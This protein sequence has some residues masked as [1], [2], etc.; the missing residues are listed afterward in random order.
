MTAADP[1]RKPLPYGRQWIDEDDVAAVVAAL[2]SDII[3]HGP[4][5][6]A[7]EQAFA[8]KV[9]AMEAVACS[10]GTAALHLALA[11]LDVAPGDVCIVPAITFLSTATAARFGGAEVVF[12]DVDPQSG[13]MTPKTLEAALAHAAR[14]VKAALPVHLGGR[15]CD[16][17]GI[18][19]VC[20]EHNITVVE[21]ASH[22]VGGVDASGAFVGGCA[23]SAAATFSFH[24]VKTLAA[25]EG[26]MATLNDGARAARMRRLRNHGVTH[27]AALMTEPESL[28]D[29]GTRKPW[30]Y[31]QIELGFNYRMNELEAA[32]GLS[33]LGKLDRFV[34]RRRALADRYEALLSPM[35]P[36]VKPAPLG[37]GEPGLH[38]FSVLIDFEAAGVR[39]AE[40]MR[41]LSADGVGTQVHY[42]PLYRQPYLKARYGEMRLP[43]A[44]T[45]YTKVMALPLFPAM[46]DGD[47]DRVVDALAQALHRAQ[48]G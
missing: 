39:R 19:R 33:Q 43:G 36:L 40:V 2:R 38:L 4:R 44:E 9:G 5:V 20:L 13:L 12:A 11:A 46:R 30:V 34:A 3:A 48:G 35:A 25:G 16:T 26:G 6:V 45:Y 22:A 23:H 1:E 47:V 32:L 21:D 10:S 41:R 18:E 14:P 24:P 7:F 8:E 31:E 37:T 29:D 15:L 28:D 27:D 17:A 42:I